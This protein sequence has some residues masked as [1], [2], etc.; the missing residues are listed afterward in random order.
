MKCKLCNKQTTSLEV[1]HIIPRIKGGTDD[2]NNLIKICIECHGKVHNVDFSKREGLIS[3][4]IQKHKK[5]LKENAEW[6]DNNMDKIQKKF[7]SIIDEDFEKAQFIS[8]LLYYEFLSA[9]NI[10]DLVLFNQAK[11][12]IR[13]RFTI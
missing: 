12:N 11:L 7:D 13:M 3:L 2:E 6:V 1:H 10:K 5:K 9:E 4:G 8:Y